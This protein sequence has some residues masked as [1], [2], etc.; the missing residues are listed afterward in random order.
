MREE[1]KEVRGGRERKIEGKG[2]ENAPEHNFWLKP[3]T[4]TIIPILYKEARR[5]GRI[6]PINWRCGF[7]RFVSVIKWSHVILFSVQGINAVAGL[8][9]GYT[10]SILVSFPLLFLYLSKMLHVHLT[11]HSFFFESNWILLTC[12]CCCYC[13]GNLTGLYS[14]TTQP[15]KTIPWWS[16]VALPSS[17]AACTIR[18]CILSN[19]VIRC[20][21]EQNASYIR[22]PDKCRT[23]DIELYRTCDNNVEGFLLQRLQ[24]REM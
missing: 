22:R 13:S 19:T 24:V 2:I 7:N 15:G 10:S 21:K 16:I 5:H 18:D 20:S 9:T 1:K 14:E 6:C 8:L 17:S 12:G 4:L 11:H 23:C 3:W